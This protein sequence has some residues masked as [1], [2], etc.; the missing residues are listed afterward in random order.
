MFKPLEFFAT[1]SAYQRQSTKKT[2]ASEHFSN[3]KPLNQK[4]FNGKKASNPK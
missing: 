2:N 1:N 4:K 3:A